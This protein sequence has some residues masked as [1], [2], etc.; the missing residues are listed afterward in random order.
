V[1][2][3]KVEAELRASAIAVAE[4]SMPVTDMPLSMKGFA[5]R[6]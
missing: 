1:V 4:S 2:D 5:L 3:R 6:P